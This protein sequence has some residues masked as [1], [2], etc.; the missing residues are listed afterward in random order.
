MVLRHPAC[1]QTDSAHILLANRLIMRVPA[2]HGLVRCEQEIAS[3]LPALPDTSPGR[4][5]RILRGGQNFAWLL[6]SQLNDRLLSAVRQHIQ[7]V[8]DRFHSL[9]IFYYPVSQGSF[10]CGV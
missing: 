2:R 3:D 1:A 7:L 6:V 4:S 10:R 5:P 8:D 9:G